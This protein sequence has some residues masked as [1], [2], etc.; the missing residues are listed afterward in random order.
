M[1][2]SKKLL[3]SLG[4]EFDPYLKTFFRKNTHYPLNHLNFISEK[5]LIK[6]KTNSTEYSCTTLS[7]LLSSIYFA[8][9]NEGQR[10]KQIEIKEA[11]D[12]K[13]LNN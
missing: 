6:L 13:D 9:I 1:K 2:I 7:N 10:Q 12:W 5:G 3:K 8:G 11:L 4:F